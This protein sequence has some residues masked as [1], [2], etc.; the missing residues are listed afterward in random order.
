[1]AGGHCST[2]AGRVVPPNG[3][4]CE[5]Y[6]RYVR[7]MRKK[8]TVGG[9]LLSAAIV[10]AGCDSAPMGSHYNS[11][12]DLRF[13]YISAGGDCDGYRSDDVFETAAQGIVCGDS[14]RLLT[15]RSAEDLATAVERLKA[16]RTFTFVVGI[17]WLVTEGIDA[18]RVADGLGGV[19]VSPDFIG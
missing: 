6:L 2:R 19:V 7:L 4:V 11:V 1:M 16:H 14:A 15:F 8:A 9:I 5:T 13:D 10:L 12:R 3:H 17:N 18:Q